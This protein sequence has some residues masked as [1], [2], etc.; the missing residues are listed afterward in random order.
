MSHRSM[1][2]VAKPRPGN[3]VTIRARTIDFSYWPTYRTNRRYG[4]HSHVYASNPWALIQVSTR[5]R[6]PASS[7][8]E[9]LASLEQAEF[10]YRSAA[11]ARESA[12]KPLPL[13][14]CFMNLAKAFALVRGIRST[15][16]RA[17]H[18]LTEQ[19]GAGGK[20]LHDAFLEA[21]PSPGP[22]GPN[23]FA[24]FGAALSA[25]ITAKTK[26]PLSSLLAQIVPGHRIWCDAAGED[27]RF[28]AIEGI[29]FAHTA[30]PKQ[31]WATI[32]LLDDD[33]QRVGKTRKDLL[34]ETRLKSLF[35]DVEGYQDK[36]GRWVVQLEQLAPTAYTG[37][38]ADKLASVVGTLRPY[39]WSTATTIRPFRRYY[40]YASPV[41]E[42]PNLLPQA[43]S[44]YAIT[45]YLGSIT[46]YRP[47]HFS[48][49]LAGPFGEFIQEFLSSQPSQFVYLMASDF[50]KRDVA[51]APLV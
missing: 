19:L 25:P 15:F 32:R 40:L 41:A 23:I 50:A 38:T 24:D 34:K 27:E 28:F 31:V 2:K 51:R 48:K 45:H 49:I 26:F 47:Q 30:A 8:E 21:Y 18:G 39:I 7:R 22:R 13:Y 4:L 9:A 5:L 29:P 42:H 3:P 11:G 46:R 14:Y 37:R 10:F 36:N 1:P 35:R 6:C 16:D 33:L 12:A 17:Q 43:M 20:E 44:I